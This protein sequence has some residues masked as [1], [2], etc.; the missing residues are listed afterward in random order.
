[1]GVHS[2]S[3]KQAITSVQN[4]VSIKAPLPRI[5]HAPTVFVKAPL[6]RT[7]YALALSREDEGLG[8]KEA[9]QSWELKARVTLL[10]CVSLPSY[11]NFMVVVLWVTC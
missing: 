8:E 7:C 6:P 1:M 2:I 3:R 9:E 11:L 4:T 5:C 10:P